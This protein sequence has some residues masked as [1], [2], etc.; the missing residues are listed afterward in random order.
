MPVS[1]KRKISID[2]NL[3]LL[4]IYYL[5]TI[6]LGPSDANRPHQWSLRLQ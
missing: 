4:L 6:A 3:A 2:D 5:N 1:S